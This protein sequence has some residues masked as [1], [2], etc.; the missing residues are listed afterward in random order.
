M[1]LGGL[2]KREKLTIANLNMA[3]LLEIITWN[4]YSDL[5]S[6]MEVDHETH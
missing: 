5:M 4:Q 3:L 1:D 2:V 6:Q